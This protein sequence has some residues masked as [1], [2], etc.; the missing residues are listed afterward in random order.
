[1]TYHLLAD[2]FRVHTKFPSG[3]IVETRREF[4]C[5]YK[6]YKFRIPCDAM[7]DVH[8]LS[9]IYNNFWPLAATLRSAL[10][11]GTSL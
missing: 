3:S 7:Y 9:V 1:M 5:G 11:A 2:G 6:M 4:L 10:H 8:R